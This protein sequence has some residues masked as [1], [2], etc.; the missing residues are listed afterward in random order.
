MTQKEES[1]AGQFVDQIEAVQ[2]EH[3]L[4]YGEEIG[5]GNCAYTVAVI[6]D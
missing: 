3:I 5:L 6:D 4:E 1:F 2:A